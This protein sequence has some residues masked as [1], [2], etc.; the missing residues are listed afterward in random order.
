MKMYLL[1]IAVALAS[2]TITGCGGK[3]CGSEKDYDWDA[4]CQA[5][6]ALTNTCAGTKFNIDDCLNACTKHDTCAASC[7]TDLKD[8]D[9]PTCDDVVACL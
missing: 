9:E 7:M 6:L 4:F 5:C 2:L 8:K 1:A 3:D